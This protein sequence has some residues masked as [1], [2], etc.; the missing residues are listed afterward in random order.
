MITRKILSYPLIGASLFLFFAATIIHTR[1]YYMG[2]ENITYEL[3]IPRQVLI[4]HP[5]FI[6][7]GIKHKLEKEYINYYEYTYFYY[8]LF[9]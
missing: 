4:E 6:K 8:Y 5:A 7:M 9:G 2:E 1:E 3:N